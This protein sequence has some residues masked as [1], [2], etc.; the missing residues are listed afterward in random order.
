MPF[1]LSCFASVFDSCDQ[2]SSINLKHSTRF[3]FYC[4]K[5]L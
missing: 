1:R 5:V 2:C 4:F 3:V